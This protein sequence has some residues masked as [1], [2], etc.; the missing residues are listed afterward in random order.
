MKM[1]DTNKVLEKNRKLMEKWNLRRCEAEKEGLIKFY[2]IKGQLK[3]L[4][5]FINNNKNN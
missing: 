5:E 4:K 1:T 2:K 3:T